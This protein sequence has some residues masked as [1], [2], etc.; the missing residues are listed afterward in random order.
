MFTPFEPGSEPVVPNTFDGV[1]EI[2]AA[3]KHRPAPAPDTEPELEPK[4]KRR[5][6][7]KV[8]PDSTGSVDHAADPVDVILNHQPE[9]EPDPEPVTVVDTA[10][11][12]AVEVADAVIP[13]KKKHRKHRK[14]SK[15]LDREKHSV[16]YEE[17]SDAP[18]PSTTREKD[19]AKVALLCAYGANEWLGPYLRDTHAFD[20]DPVK[21]RKLKG[22][23]LDELVNEVEDVLANKSNN[24]IGDGLVRGSLEFLEKVIDSKTPFKVNG[25][26]DKCF[27]NDHWRFLLERTKLKYGFNLGGLDPVS[28]LSLVTFQT[29]A[30][31]HY[32]NKFNTPTT[33]LDA[34]YELPIGPD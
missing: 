17:A 16:S 15:K 29:A 26:I 23:K 18:P 4:R 20:L 21:L 13:E 31:M 12:T 34:P 22:A 6:T 8:V 28:E 30:M 24:A 5:K 9:P 19:R 27:A 32:Q 2:V 7:R 1:A 14:Q 10:V 11:R 33:N 25:T 3:K